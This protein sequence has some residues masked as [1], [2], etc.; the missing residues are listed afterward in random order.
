MA[1][2]APYFKQGH[3]LY[4]NHYLPED[5]I[6]LADVFKKKLRRNWIISYDNHPQIRKAYRGCQRLIYS[7]P[8]SAARRYEGSEVMFFSPDLAV[9]PVKNPLMD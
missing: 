9:P 5:H 1:I 3:S 8:Y 6:R 7:L 4:E 2:P